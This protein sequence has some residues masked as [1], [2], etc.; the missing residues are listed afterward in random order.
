VLGL[1]AS[2]KTVYIAGPKVSNLGRMKPGDKVQVT[3]A[4]QLTICVSNDGS[5][6]EGSDGAATIE[7]RAKVL[8]VDPSYR[9]LTLQHPDGRLE[10][11]K[12]GL[13][14]RLS[15]MKAGDDVVIRGVETVAFRVL[16]P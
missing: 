15:Q 7:T 16:E 2:E 9:L 10:T 5:L 11:F 3:V 13:D 6:G 8:R 14:A 1:S 12:V 4:E